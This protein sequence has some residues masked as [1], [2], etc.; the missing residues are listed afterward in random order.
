MVLQ[1]TF[2]TAGGTAVLT[3][4]LAVGR[5]ERGHDL[6][7]HSPSM[8]LRP[9]HQ[10]RDRG[11]GQLRA[12]AG[13]RPHPPDPGSGARR[14]RQPGRCRPAALVHPGSLTVDGATATARVRLGA[15][16]D[17]AFAFGHEELAGLPRTP[18]TAAEI[19]SRLDDTVDGWRSWSAIHQNYEGPWRDLVHHSGR[20]WL[21]ALMFEPTGAI[22]AS[23]TTSLPETVGGGTGTTA[24]R[25]YSTPA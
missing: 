24:T 13:V 1:T 9:L 5:N 21:Q 7:A 16:Q 20:V 3:D 19:S 4:A 25:G 8:L 23:P 6:G 12:P 10:R 22:V 15:G 17:A 18:W 2:T 14:P 11:G